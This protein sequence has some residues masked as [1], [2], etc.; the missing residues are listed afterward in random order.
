MPMNL[1]LDRTALPKVGNIMFKYLYNIYSETEA[2]CTHQ[3]NGEYI[4]AIVFTDLAKLNRGP[5]TKASKVKHLFNN[6]ELDNNQAAIN[7][8]YDKEYEIAILRD[9]THRKIL[10]DLKALPTIGHNGNGNLKVSTEDLRITLS[11]HTKADGAPFE[12]QVFV[13][14]LLTVAGKPDWYLV[15]TYQA[16]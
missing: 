6:Y 7:S 4:A 16:K 14:R 3:S 5:N 8:L 2:I 9:I 13:S 11:T 15:D 12:N 10:E 1:I